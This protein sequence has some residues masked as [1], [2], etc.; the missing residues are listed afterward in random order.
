MFLC[1]LNYRRPG[2][3]YTSDM[4]L[5]HALASV[6]ALIG[7]PTRAAILVAL[8]DGRALPAGELAREA[9]LSASATSLHLAKMIEGGLL[10]VEKQGRHRL[11]RLASNDVAS[12]LEALGVIATPAPKGQPISAQRALLREARTCYDHLAGARAVAFTRLLEDQA[13]LRV[14]SDRS[15][16]LSAEG[17]RWFAEHLQI[18]VGSL[19]SSRRALARRCMDWT[20]RRPH[21]AGALGAALLERLL[22]RRYVARTTGSRALRITPT[23]SAFFVR[24][25]RWETKAS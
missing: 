25:D 22:A 8:L 21:L 9:Q 3:G 11:Y 13:I 12:A 19:A 7:E 17:R 6:A 1:A 15:Y 23:G 4:T 14:S 20:E 16:E 2:L 24:L 18:D 5:Q 10:L